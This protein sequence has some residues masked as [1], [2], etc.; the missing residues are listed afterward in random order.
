MLFMVVERFKDGDAR[1][2]GERFAREGR[3]LPDGLTYRGSWME[4]SGARC[5]QLMET[6]RPELF[7]Q[8]TA[9]WDDLVTFEIV[10]VEDAASFWARA[11]SE[12][13]RE[14]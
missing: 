12:R 9:R 6:Q 1:P 5:F 2:A 14:R 13:A 11:S 10:P 3:M 7:A 4:R 8:W